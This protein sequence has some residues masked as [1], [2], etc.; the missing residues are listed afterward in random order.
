MGNFK[1][2]KEVYASPMSRNAKN[3]KSMKGSNGGGSVENGG[4]VGS[5]H[6]NRNGEIGQMKHLD[7]NQRSRSTTQ[8]NKLRKPRSK[9]NAME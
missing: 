4:S 2:D 7:V 9:D 5:P 1:P 6:G 3:N 8:N